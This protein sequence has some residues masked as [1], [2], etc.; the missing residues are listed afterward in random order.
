MRGGFRFPQSL[1]DARVLL[2][3]ARVLRV[4]AAA[5][6]VLTLGLT[7]YAISLFRGLPD[8]EAIR[9]IGEMDQATTVFDDQAQL[10]FTLFREQRIDATLSEMSPHLARAIVAV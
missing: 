10:A 6:A 3:D 1:K 9:H 2:K 7:I 8:D 5:V 4:T